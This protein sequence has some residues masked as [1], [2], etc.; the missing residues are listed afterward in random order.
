M[1]S[2][3][4][5]TPL[6]SR[7]GWVILDALKLQGWHGIGAAASVS[8]TR[9]APKKKTKSEYSN[10]FKYV[11]NFQISCIDRPIELYRSKKVASLLI[12]LIN[13]ARQHLPNL[14]ILGPHISLC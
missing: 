10:I 11:Y 4:I 12:R 2:T 1:L 14:F 6:K 7:F 9:S 3:I 5:Y 13:Y 8:Q